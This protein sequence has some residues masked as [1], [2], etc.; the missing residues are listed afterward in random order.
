M[1][2][3]RLLI[4]AFVALALQLTVIHLSRIAGA[5]PDL[6]FLVAAYLAF[7]LRIEDLLVPIW[8]LGLVK[9]CASVA[10]FGAFGFLFTLSGVLLS[11]LKDFLFRDS[12]LVQVSLVF[13]GSLLYNCLFGLDLSRASDS[14]TWHW[15]VERSVP[16]ALYTSLC[17]PLLFVVLDGMRR[18]LGVNR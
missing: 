18:Y 7:H 5:A 11:L 15:A 8:I 14:L 17:A 4:V 13:L 10:E 9:D 1:R 16:S 2:I 6:L 3:D 12:L